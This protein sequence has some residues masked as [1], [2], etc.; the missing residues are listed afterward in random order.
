MYF[1]FK[2]P[3]SADVVVHAWLPAA[4]K[5]KCGIAYVQCQ[6]GPQSRSIKPT[7]LHNQTLFFEQQTNK[8]TFKSL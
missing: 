6:P 7:S 4:T 1:F 5:Q 2:S 8:Q 3:K